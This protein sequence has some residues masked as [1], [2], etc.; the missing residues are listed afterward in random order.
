[1]RS[2]R[3][4]AN[5][6]ITKPRDFERFGEVIGRIEEFFAEVARLPRAAAA[7]PDLPGSTTRR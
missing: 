1:M 6:Y 2:Y 3:L 5:A 4:H 7:D